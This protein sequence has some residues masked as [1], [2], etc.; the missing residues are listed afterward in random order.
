[1][2]RYVGIDVAPKKYA[3]CIVDDAGTILFEGSG[4][5]GPDEIVRT[6]AAEVGDVEKVVHESGPLSIW[7]TRELI[8]RQVPMVCIDARAAHKVLSARM[9]VVERTIRPIA[10]QRKN[11]LFAGYD[12]GTQN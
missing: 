11:A 8:K 10:L 6:I 5:T 12:A 1:M 4:A 9:N 3:L 7:L 2:K